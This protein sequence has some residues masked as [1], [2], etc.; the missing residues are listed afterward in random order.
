MEEDTT[1]PRSSAICAAARQCAASSRFRGS[2]GGHT[3]AARVPAR[4]S[5]RG[6]SQLLSLAGFRLAAASEI[7]AGAALDAQAVTVLYRLPD[8][9]WIRGTA[10]RCTRTTRFLHLT[11]A[12][13]GRTSALG[14]AEMPLA[15]RSSRASRPG[16][17]AAGRGPDRLRLRPM[18]SS[19][20]QL[21]ATAREDLGDLVIS[22]QAAYQ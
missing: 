3:P 19:V 7:L 6:P 20:D 16:C 5:G 10:V 8:E 12:R 1:V 17:P 14:A 21:T 4:V 9:G 18:H 13:Y 11:V 22:S 15:G 2:V